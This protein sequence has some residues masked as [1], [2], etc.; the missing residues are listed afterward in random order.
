MEGGGLCIMELYKSVHGATFCHQ[1]SCSASS[2]YS[3]WFSS[4]LGSIV[5]LLTP[6]TVMLLVTYLYCFQL[7]LSVARESFTT[8]RRR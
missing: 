7:K 4:I 1:V 8:R 2:R 3:V 6:F 5:L